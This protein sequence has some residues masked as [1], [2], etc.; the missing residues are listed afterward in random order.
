MDR[1]CELVLKEGEE[2]SKTGLLQMKTKEVD[3][4]F[5]K[6]FSLSSLYDQF[7]LLYPNTSRILHA[8]GTSK[9]QEKAQSEKAASKKEKVK[10]TYRNIHNRTDIYIFFSHS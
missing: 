9:Q 3:P 6:G 1:V 8:F 4:N 10:L 7:Y 5:R 2:I